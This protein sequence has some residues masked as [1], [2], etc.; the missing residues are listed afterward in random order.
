MNIGEKTVIDG[1]EKTGCGRAHIG[2]C[3]SDKNLHKV[4]RYA[5]LGKRVQR[6]IVELH[7]KHGGFLAY[8]RCEN[9]WVKE[10]IF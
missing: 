1:L 10:L 4:V 2:Q 9:G 7:T 8:F 5:Y 3:L 6:G